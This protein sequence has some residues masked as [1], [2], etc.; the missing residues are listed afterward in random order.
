MRNEDNDCIRY[1]MK[2][3]DPSEEVLMERAMM[4][5]ENLLIEVESMRQTLHKLDNLPE[6]EPPSHLTESI[7]EKA[8][9]QK[10][11]KRN[12]FIPI[13]PAVKYT[14]A[15]AVA[16]TVTAGGMW[17]SVDSYEG[18]YTSE[19]NIAAESPSA[20][21]NSPVNSSSL[22]STQNFDASFLPSNEDGISPWVDRNDIIRFEDQFTNSGNDFDSIL[23][24]TT[25]RLRPLHES[26]NSQEGVR[27]F[28]LT[29]GN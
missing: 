18:K 27:S 19:G 25:Q 13:L 17:L 20:A 29:G 16:L 5:D 21:D 8:A 28:Q 1:L 9:R 11:H 3:M 24:T 4:E 14:V 15:A 12:K 2:E 26:L 6:V 10:E 7:V 23:Q 22:I